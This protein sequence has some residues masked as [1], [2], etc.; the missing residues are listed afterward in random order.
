MAR[1]GRRGSGLMAAEIDFL[2]LLICL[3]D[4]AMP[5]SPPSGD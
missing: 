2:L 5:S 4:V 3:Q 1:M